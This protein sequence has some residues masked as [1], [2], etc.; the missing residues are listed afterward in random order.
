MKLIQRIV[1]LAVTVIAVGFLGISAAAARHPDQ[2]SC[3]PVTTCGD[4]ANG[5]EATDCPDGYACVCVP[6]CPDCRDCAAQVCVPSNTACHSACD[7]PDGMGCAGG[8]C[9]EGAGPVHCCDAEQ[10]PAGE[11]CENRLGQVDLC[12][13]E[14]RTACDCPTGLS[15]IS[16]E[17]IAGIAPVYCCGGDTCPAGEQCQSRSGEMGRC[18]VQP[19][20]R[21]ACDCDPG[22]GC[23]EG[24]CIAGVAPVFCCEGDQCPAGDQCQHRD[25]RMD[26]CEDQCVDQAWLCDE[27]DDRNCGEGRIC[28]CT[29]SCPDCEDCGTNVCMP[30]DRPTP[31]RCDDDG[32]CSQPRDRC[33]CVSSCP[34]CDDCALSVCVPDCENDP[35]CKKRLQMTQRRIHHVLEKT[36]PCRADDE[37]VEVDNSTGCQGAC[38]AYVNRRWAP[39][40]Q[41]FIDQVDERLCTGYQEDGCPYATPRCVVT[42][43]AC[44]D[45]RCTSVPVPAPA[46]IARVRTEKRAAT[47]GR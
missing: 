41:N 4:V 44:V 42:A 16:G 3:Q 8:V 28:G 32:T 18:Q 10:C 37:C 34:G 43:G 21:T 6:S 19:E 25:G 15:C 17:C 31:Y 27:T 5:G 38:G 39:R 45:N 24:Q 30:P 2:A 12:Q 1:G 14:C 26:R 40:V 20:C 23:F 13:R 29:A 7:C 46:P 22:L 33:I 9:R 35:M 11:R 47:S 36:R